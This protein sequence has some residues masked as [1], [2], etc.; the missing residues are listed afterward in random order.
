M[1]WMRRSAGRAEPLPEL[2]SPAAQQPAVEYP[3]LGLKTALEQ[4]PRPRASVLDLG[5]P[6]AANV[7]RFNALKVDVRLRVADLDAAIDD[8]GLREAP[9][10]QWE[11]RLGELLPWPEAERFDLVLAWDLPNYVGRDRWPKLVQRIVA[12]LAPGGAFHVLVRVGQTMP[13]H[14]CRFRMVRDGVV[15]EENLTIDTLPAPRLPHAEVEK[16]HPGLVAPRSHLGKQGVQEY[17]L[18]HAAV[19]NL[20]PRR[21]AQARTRPPSGA[22]RVPY[23]EPG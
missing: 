17:L 6:L 5:P 21:V 10:A 20:P 13:S 4:L 16:L 11:R 19:H 7:A 14:P 12:Q 15:A 18:E 9:V 23:Q 8:L 2:L 3:A 22:I 1:S